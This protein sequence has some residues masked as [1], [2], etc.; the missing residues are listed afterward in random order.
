MKT[1]IT[2]VTLISLLTLTSCQLINFNNSSSN[3]TNNQSSNISSI[4]QNE[5]SESSYSSENISID[6][7][8]LVN[9]FAIND[10]HGKIQKT[11][12]YP[13]I[14][15][16]QG[17]I[18]SDKNYNSDNSL[19][20]SS[21]DMFQGSYYS[22]YSKGKDLI[23]MM[24]DFSFK[25]MT[26]GNHEF[27][28]GID[29]LKE[30]SDIATF[31]FL[32]ANILN[33]NN[34]EILPFVKAYTIV[35]VNNL[36]LGIVGAIG[37]LESSIKEGMLGDYYFSNDLNI[38][39]KAYDEC[40]KNGADGVI[41]SIHDDMDSSF[42]NSI[43]NSKIPFLGMFGGHSHKFQLDKQGINY[44]Q[45]GSDSKGYSYGQF[46]LQNDRLI[47]LNYT[48]LNTSIDYST[49][50]NKEF[51]KLVNTII[52]SIPVQKVGYIKGNW[53]KVNSANLVLRAMFEMAKIIYPNKNYTKDNLVAI[54]NTAGIRGSF[55]S[56][57]TS[58]ELSIEDV[59]VVSP[60][61]NKVMLLENRLYSYSYIN[62]ANH[63]TYPV[64]NN[65][66]DNKYYDIITIDYL[67]TD[68][69]FSQMF[70]P[71]SSKEV[72]NKEGDTYYIFDFIADYI[73]NNSSKESPLLASDFNTNI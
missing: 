62:R 11:N 27:D 53:N 67:V 16:L 47:S 34:N 52:N 15:N 4:T 26:I 69:Y 71:T 8:K 21:G 20:I 66:M 51:I 24:N 29:A 28:W 13:G 33:K 73:L 55:P 3:S 35:N 42:V 30:L 46:D 6:K 2:L 39:Q 58:Y 54:H 7:D 25:S 38:L 9:V 48:Q 44:V 10:F 57:Q 50:A 12:S 18:F 22:Y 56:S 5:S 61:D 14:I 59:Q 45:G 17:A 36:K 64:N 37:Q 68:K 72:K 19:I 32:G 23:K 65:S 63:Y 41:L 31:P 49:S 70:S 1:K 43:Q 60:F 40:I